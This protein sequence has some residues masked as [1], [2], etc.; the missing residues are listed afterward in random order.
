MANTALETLDDVLGLATERE[1]ERVGTALHAVLL[2]GGALADF[3]ART[4]AILLARRDG[5]P[6]ARELACASPPTRA[7]LAGGLSVISEPWADE[8]LMKLASDGEARVRSAVAR[9]GVDTGRIL[10]ADRDGLACVLPANVPAAVNLVAG[11]SFQSRDERPLAL[12]EDAVALLTELAKNAACEPRLDETELVELATLS[13]I[14]RLVVE[15]CLARISWLRAEPA[16]DFATM[17]ARDSLPDELATAARE[18][19]TDADRTALL[20]LVG[21]SDLDGSARSAATTL[22]S[23]IDDDRRVTERIGTWLKTNREHLHQLASELLRA[24][25]DPARFKARGRALL[26]LDLSVDLTAI[27]LDAREPMWLVGPERVV[28]RQLADEFEKWAGDAEP[29]LAAVGRAGVARFRARADRADDSG[30]PEETDWG[31][32][33][34]RRL[35]RGS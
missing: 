35:S 13:G 12:S 20:D 25:R 29:R 19:A 27:L 34:Q 17:F 23:W 15:A 31:R 2:E 22:I 28:H 33:R 7:A 9:A 26:A 10:S 4:L 32:R 6:H 5:E 3:A 11:L 21:D 8:L 18:G 16:D 24:T 1:P 14:P 30:E